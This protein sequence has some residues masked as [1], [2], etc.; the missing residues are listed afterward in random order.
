MSCILKPRLGC[1]APKRSGVPAPSP[2]QRLLFLSQSGRIIF[3][4]RLPRL[5]HQPIRPRHGESARKWRSQPAQWQ[6]PGR[7]APP[8]GGRAAL[9]RTERPHFKVGDAGSALKAAS[10][11]RGVGGRGCGP[12]GPCRLRAHVSPQPAQHARPPCPW[13]CSRGGG[14][15]DAGGL[16]GACAAGSV[17]VRGREES[18]GRNRVRHLALKS[19]V[20]RNGPARGRRSR[21]GHFAALAKCQALG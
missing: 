13:A 19:A 5:H 16:Q 21:E 17:G 10:R 1:P 11:Q 4:S 7:Q 2:F 9:H 3:L 8:L 14:D 6:R 18:Q 20:E 15:R 12:R